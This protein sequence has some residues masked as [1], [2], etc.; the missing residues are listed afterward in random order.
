[1][2]NI[3]G[4][5]ITTLSPIAVWNKTQDDSSDFFSTHLI[6]HFLW[7]IASRLLNIIPKSRSTNLV[8]LILLLL[9]N[10]PHIRPSCL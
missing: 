9:I 10:V 1:M 3:D 2:F 5:G 8:S 6:S 4:V 7:Q